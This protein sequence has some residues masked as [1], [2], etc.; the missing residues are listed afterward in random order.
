MSIINLTPH[1]VTLVG[2]DGSLSV[3]PRTGVVARL[4][5]T[6][7][8]D[9][10]F[11]GVPFVKTRYGDVVDLPEEKSMTVY[12]VSAL[13]RTAMSHRRDLVSPGALVRDTDGKI[14]GCREFICN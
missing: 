9:R 1:D 3:F 14:I 4:T 7:I 13:I 5:E 2:D 6:T 10:M 8:L 12:I 11:A